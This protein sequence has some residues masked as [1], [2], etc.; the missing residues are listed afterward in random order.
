M[1]SFTEFEIVDSLIRR[2]FRIQDITSGTSQ[3]GYIRRFRGSLIGDS[4]QAYD[5]LSESLKPHHLTPL[6]R[7]EDGQHVILLV[8]Q[9]PAVKMPDSRINLLMFILTVI[10]VIASGGLYAAQSA[11]PTDPWQLTVFLVKT[12][13]PFAVS[14]M[15]ILGTHELAHYFAGRAHGVKVTLPFFIPLPMTMLGTM[16]AFISMRSTPKNK[17]ELLDI[18]VAGP[19]AGFIVALIVLWIGL[20]QSTLNQIPATVSE[21]SGYMF[22]GNSLL[23]LLFKYL[24]FGKLLP[25]PATTGGLPLIVFWLKYFFTGRPF[26]LGSLDVTISPV[27]WA[28]WVGLLV[29]SLNLI[30]AGQLDGG[31]IFQILFGQKTARRILPFIAGV[32]VLLGIAWSG[33]WLWVVIVLFLGRRYAEPLDQITELDPK[34]KVLGYLAMFILLI[35]FIPIPFTVIY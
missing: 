26:P 32:L 9:A 12:G 20:G 17:R 29:T 21:A 34:R 8:P 18:G 31:H 1:D 5:S 13:W 2:V 23:Y 7:K 27:A 19:L 14:L 6:F 24:H 33:W 30:P 3:Q 22:E 16:G 15:A 10:S 11:L 4:Q 28:G 35:T 25:E